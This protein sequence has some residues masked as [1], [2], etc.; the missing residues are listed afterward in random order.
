MLSQISAALIS[1]T[2]LVA[3]LSGSVANLNKLPPGNQRAQVYQT[4]TV[5]PPELPRSYVD[6]TYPTQSLSRT[7]RSVK[8]SCTGFSNCYT[9]LQ[10][11]IDSAIQG[12]EIVIDNTLTI[13][14]PIYLRNKTTGSG[15]IVIR[16]SS[17]YSLPPVGVRVS[18]ANSSVMPKIVSPGSNL[19]AIQTDESAH[20][21]RL[22]GLEVIDAPNDDTNVLVQLG[23]GDS[24]CATAT[25]LYKVC[26]TSVLSR[27]ATD[28][29]LDRMYIHGNGNFAVKRGV[30]LDSKNSAIIDSYVSNIHLIGQ[31]SQALAATWGPGPY[32][33]VNNYFEGSGENVIFGG[34]DPRVINLIPSDIEFRNNHLYKPRTWKV[35][36]STYAGINW[37]VK[38]L[39]ELKNAQRVLIQGNVFDGSWVDGQSGYAIVFTS[40]NQD[41]RCT[42]CVVKDINFNN[43]IVRHASSGLAMNG[44]DD[45]YPL[46]P[47]TERIKVTNNLWDDINGS[48][49]GGS[50]WG[51]LLDGGTT[52]PGPLNIEFSNNTFMQSG[53]AVQ[54]GPYSSTKPSSV[55]I[56]NIFAHNDYGFMGESTGPGNSTITSYFP[57]VVFQKNI[58]VG[59]NSS[60]YSSYPGS[61]FPATWSEVL[62]NKAGGD[63]NVVSTSIYNNGGTDGKDIGVDLATLSSNTAG[64]VSGNNPNIAVYPT[65][66]YAYPT[67]VYAYPTPTSS[68][69]TYPTPSTIDTTAPVISLFDVQ[70]RITTGSVTASFSATDTGGSNINKAEL[71]R[72]TINTATC[73][74]TSMS[75]CVW[76]VVYTVLAPSGSTSWVSTI[77]DLPGLGQYIYGLHI[78]DGAGNYAVEPSTV[79][80]TV[81]SSTTYP[82]PTTSTTT[83]PTP[84]YEYPTPTTTYPTPTTGC[85]VVTSSYSPSKTLQYGDTGK[86]V[87]DLQKFLYQKCDLDASSITGNFLALTRDGLKKYQ[88]DAGIVCSGDEATTGWGVLGPKTREYIR[89]HQ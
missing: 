47:V 32:K 50:G 31:D 12:D 42:W 7:V 30:G 4:P 79:L 78:T 75:G 23:T 58:L 13:T 70:P 84:A 65:P 49:W 81:N 72:T 26:D 5:V 89:L 83:Y 37:S 66:A 82:T 14:G 67:P 27:F 41:G 61:F 86:R 15:W 69:T 48:T 77:S 21:Y 43:N 60:W 56:N 24:Y 68:T 9:S 17:L 39:F 16:T 55:F 80:V 40:R 1:L 46:D 38:N 36:D 20:N 59:G 19:S 74:T 44:H 88:C 63:Y 52:A 11:A 57:N 62:V 33:V 64:A 3:S 2:A 54:S 22:V 35:G 6:T 34:D 53:S 45:H 51:V 73:T 29:I 87:S 76:G 28:I 85:T 18:P 10:L 25:E 71:Y 8:A